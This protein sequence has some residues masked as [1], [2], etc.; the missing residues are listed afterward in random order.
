GYL[1]AFPIS[2]FE[3]LET[4][5]TSAQVPFYTIHKIMAGLVD[6]Y[7]Y[8]GITQAVDM[9][10]AMSDYHSTRMSRLTALQIEAMFVAKTGATEWGGMNETLTD[11][12][13]LSSA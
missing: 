4:T 11:I 12:Y 3:T 10:I 7:R 6:A 9:A 8:A 1:S 5:P 2:Y 13:Q